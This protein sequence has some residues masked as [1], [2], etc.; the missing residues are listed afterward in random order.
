METKTF[1]YFDTDHF[2]TDIS[3]LELQLGKVGVAFVDLQRPVIPEDMLALAYGLGTPIKETSPLALA[4]ADPT[5]HI[6]RITSKRENAA[7]MTEQV[8][9]TD[10]MGMHLDHA[11]APQASQPDYVLLGCETPPTEDIGGQ[12]IMVDGNDLVRSLTYT[13]QQVL[14]RS[15]QRILDPTLTDPMTS[16]EPLLRTKSDGTRYISIWDAGKY[17]EVWDL[18]T[19]SEN[20]DIAEK[21]IEHLR[22]YSDNNAKAIPWIAGRI[23]VWDN[24][25][26]LHGRTGQSQ[27]SDRSILRAKVVK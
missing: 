5:G 27:V 19:N 22:Q 4:N 24:K 3:E 18:K 16:S 13:Q 10:Y 7:A 21:T 2:L 11:L 14:G 9:S 23:A 6:V 1:S 17:G 25:R 26:F 12:T 8:L 20:E 15:Y